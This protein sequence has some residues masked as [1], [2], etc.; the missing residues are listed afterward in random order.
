MKLYNSQETLFFT[1]SANL[2][3]N[4]LQVLDSY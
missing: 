2:S 4:A 3:A 1:G